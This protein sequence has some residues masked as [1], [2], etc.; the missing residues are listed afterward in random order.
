MEITEL[1]AQLVLQIGIILLAVRVFGH[2]AKKIGIPSVLGELLAGVLIGPYALGGITL[3]GFSNGIFPISEISGLAVSVELYAFA[4][5]ASVVLLFVS[6]LETNLRMFLRYS[7]AGGIIGITGALLAFAAGTLC[8][9]ILLKSYFFDPYCM[10]FGIIAMTSSVGI[11]ARILSERNKMDSAEGV[12]VISAGVFE[13]V[14]WIILLA[15]VIGIFSAMGGDTSSGP[16]AQGIILMALRIFGIWLG[17]TALLLICSKIFASFLKIYKNSIEFS[18]L[19]LGIAFILAG[20]LEKQDLALIIGAYI[21]GLSLSKTDI[22]GIIQERIHALYV[23]FVPMFFAIM[24]MMVNV[25]EII[26]PPVLIFGILYMLAAVFA[27][28]IGN[29][30]MAMLS[31]F[32]RLGALRI[33]AGM[34]PRGEGAL[35]T[36]GIGLAAGVISNQH[37]SAAVF[38][39]FLSIVACPPIL[40]WMLKIPGRGTKKPEKD[41]DSVSEEWMF[42]SSEIADLVMS[43][44]LGELRS[45]GFYVQTMSKDKGFTQARKDDIALF[46]TEKNKCITI[47]TSKT[48][49]PFVK[50]EIYEVIL[51]LSHNIEKLKNSADP[52]KMKKDLSDTTARTTKEILALLDPKCFTLELKGENKEDVITELVDLLEASGKLL[53]REQV[54]ADALEREKTMSTGM[55]HGIALPHAKTDGI[56]ETTAAIGIKK[57]G[58]NFESMDGEASQ[59]I[60]LIVSPKKVCG[61]YMQFLAAIAAILRDETLREEI[62][63]AA[64]PQDAVELL[65]KR[66]N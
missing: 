8:G 56:A 27:K 13:D 55:D 15:V 25:R 12:T 1:V 22:A 38:M 39:I 62:I 59:I 34:I 53:D 45:E 32:N 11:S 52:A 61:L 28:V 9:V 10:F 6:G 26:S 35:I 58:V 43:N 36:C 54:L 5:V 33:G 18:V 19:A 47:T 37:F 64:T 66:K 63:N 42:G 30:S 3:P 65:R 49:M 51:E 17:A 44:L 46:I 41:D 29:G 16:S 4:T 7:L 14:L 40:A 31:G 21:A 60:V 57:K 2:L 23:F 24:G 50:N 48:D 20:L